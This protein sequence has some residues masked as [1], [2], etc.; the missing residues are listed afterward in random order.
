MNPKQFNGTSSSLLLA[1]V[2]V[3]ALAMSGVALA[4]SQKHDDFFVS[5]SAPGTPGGKL[6]ISLRSEPRT[7]NPVTAVDQVSV[8]ILGRTM[9][10]LIHI[11]R[12]TQKSAPA[13]A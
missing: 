12:S 13:L 11:N 1:W 7:F 10:D 5:P 2:C 9:A 6:V 8:G 3:L 4:Q